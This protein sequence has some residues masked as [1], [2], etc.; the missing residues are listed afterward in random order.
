MSSAAESTERA[1]TRIQR[2]IARRMSASHTEVPDFALEADVDME[3]AVRRRR[4]RKEDGNEVP[5]YNDMIVRACA[6]AL[7]EHPKVNASWVDGSFSF[8][9][10]VNVGVAVATGEALIVPVLRHADQMSV[11]TIRAEM[12]RL[13]DDVRSGEI[14][15]E[16]LAG[17][18]FTIS[19]LGMLGIDRF[20]AMVNPPQAA[21]LAV[22][23]LSRVPAAVG[24]E[25]ELRHRL[26][27]TLSCD[28]RVLYGAEGAGF[29]GAV[30]EL[31]EKPEEIG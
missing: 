24:E 23:A 5:S 27:L 15:A 7:L 11:M 14:S 2:T 4:R 12:K 10:D 21:I 26:T 29:L 30:R 20:S 1:A 17:A 16:D 18:T 31:L 9:R 6:T 25:I 28:H 19:N 8:H 22:G 13:S 3:E